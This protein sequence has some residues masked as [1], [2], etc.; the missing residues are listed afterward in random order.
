MLANIIDSLGMNPHLD[1]YLVVEGNQELASAFPVTE[2]A[3]SSVGAAT[4]AV[5]ELLSEI[6]EIPKTFVDRRQASLWF[7]LSIHP[8]GWE[9]PAA[10][11]PLAG[12][13]EASDGWI[14]IHTNAPCH[15]AAALTV[16]QCES[17]RERV[18]DAVRLWEAEALEQAIVDAYGCAARLR[19]RPEWL[20]HPQGIA[21]TQEPLVLQ[22]PGHSSHEPSAWRPQESRPLQGLRVLDLT[23]VLAGPV[24]TRFLAGYGAEVLRLDP[25]GWDEPALAPEITLGKRCARLDLR[26]RDG[27]I[28]FEH[29]LSR[30]DIL[31]HGYRSDALDN[32]GY[33]AEKRQEIRPGLI[34]VS[35]NAYG[36]SG[37]WQGRRG[38]DSLVQF[39]TGISSEGMMWKGASSPVSLPVQALDHA[40]GYLMAAAAVRGILSRQRGEPI[41]QYR[42]SLARTAELLFHHRGPGSSGDFPPAGDTDRS[43]DSEHTPWGIACRLMPPAQIGN[44]RMSWETPAVPLGSAAPQWK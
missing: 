44:T 14:K 31:V 1:E 21:V 15:K 10:W 7:G 34:D 29:L 16:L 24:A 12:D 9:L 33:S 20:A 17:S 25:P 13:Y 22:S 19:L 36:H 11:D 40:T 26:D 8:Q 6:G 38:F 39:S 27:R 43:A 37:P 5:T 28:T 18:A 2:L 41:R 23:R 3:A 4:L 32:L 30:A 42:L 35:L